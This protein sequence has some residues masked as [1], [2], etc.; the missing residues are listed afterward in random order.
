MNKQYWEVLKMVSRFFSIFSVL[1]RPFANDST[2]IIDQ[3]FWFEMAICRKVDVIQCG[4]LI[5]RL[6]HTVL[7]PIDLYICSSHHAQANTFALPCIHINT[8]WLMRF[9]SIQVLRAFLNKNWRPSH[10]LCSVE[11]FFDIGYFQSHPSC[12]LYL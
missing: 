7:T 11:H 6:L 5:K 8:N 1:I 3:L 2:Q 9:K 10:M 4:P 12:S